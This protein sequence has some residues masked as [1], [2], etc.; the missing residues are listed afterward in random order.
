LVGSIVSM[1]GIVKYG[2]ISSAGSED[3]SVSIG[4]TAEEAGGN[5]D[6][7]IG[8]FPFANLGMAQVLGKTEGSVRVFVG[9]RSH[10]I[11]GACIT[12][13]RAEELIRVIA[14][15][16]RLNVKVE[17]LVDLV[18]AHPTLSEA[19]GEAAES[20]LGRAI[21]LMPRK[22][23]TPEPVTRHLSRDTP[24]DMVIVGSGPAG[25]VAAIRAAQLGQKAAVIEKGRLGGTCLIR[26]CIPTKTIL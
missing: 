17:D 9:K 16:V 24:Y 19:V 25:Y 15:A 22:A 8:E 5:P 11:L 4:M 26:G 6:V 12:G 20:A 18:Y 2:G 10:E 13:F 3:E 23:S 21:H 1:M 7:L 14:L